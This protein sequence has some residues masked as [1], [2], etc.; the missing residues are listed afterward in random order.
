M[1][2]SGLGYLNE[3]LWEGITQITIQTSLYFL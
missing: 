1:Q 3:I 2:V